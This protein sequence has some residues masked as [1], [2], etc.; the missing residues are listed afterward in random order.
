MQEKGLLTKVFDLANTKLDS[1]LTKAKKNIRHSQDRKAFYAEENSI[2]DQGGWIEKSSIIPFDILRQISERDMVATAII[3]KIVNRVAAFARPQKDRYSLGY[4]FRLRD[5]DQKQVKKKDIKNIKQLQK[6]LLYTGDVTPQR[7]KGDIRNFDEFLR[8]I[9]RDAL[10]YNQI[11]IE[12]IYNKSNK[13]SYFVPVAGGSIRYAV[14][15]LKDKVH[16]FSELIFTPSNVDSREKQIA[17]LNAKLD[18]IKYVQVYKNQILTAFTEEELIYKQRV[19]SVEIVYAGYAPGELEWLINTI[20]SHRIAE[21]HNEIFFK[22]GHAGNGILNIKSEMTDEDLIGI[23]RMFQRQAQGVR[24][25]HRQIIFAVPQGLEWHAMSQMTNRDMEFSAWMDYLIK[26]MC[27]PPNTQVLL[28]KGYTNI[29]NIKPNDK[30]VTHNGVLKTVK[31]TQI[32]DF[33]GDL[34]VVSGYGFPDIKCT[35]EHPFYVAEMDSNCFARDLPLGYEVK[36]VW[37]KANELKIGDRLVV[38]KS[39]IN[40]KENCCLDAA[41]VL[42]NELD[43]QYNEEKIWLKGCKVEIPRWFDL[44]GIFGEILGWYAAKGHH[45][46]NYT[47]FTLSDLDEQRWGIITR[48]SEYFE[49]IG[50]QVSV[51][52]TAENCWRVQINSKIFSML[53]ATICGQNSTDKKVPTFIDWSK[54]AAKQFLIGY[55][56]GDGCIADRCVRTSSISKELS[57]GIKWL[58]WKLGL[59]ASI[60]LIPSVDYDDGRNRKD[61]W[62]VRCGGKDFLAIFPEFGLKEQQVEKNGY[63]SDEN[64][65]YPVIR[66]ITLEPYKGL[67][68]NLEVED[69]NSYVVEGLAVHNCAVY[70]INPSEIN[71]DISRGDSAPSLSDS[72][73]RNEVILK[74]TRNSSLRP[75]L[76]WI[77]TVINDEILPKYDKE[78]AEEYLFEFVGLDMED[79]QKELDRIKA[80]ISTYCTINEIRAEYQLDPEPYGDIILDTVYLQYRLA[81]EEQGLMPPVGP[82]GKPNTPKVGEGGDAESG[83]GPETSDEEAGDITGLLNEVLAEKGNMQKYLDLAKAMKRNGK[84]LDDIRNV[85]KRLVLNEK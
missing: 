25:A 78:L 17:E 68:Y 20:A 63:C 70:G 33:D 26:L 81:K 29:E 53:F 52:K 77:E 82:D 41:M 76:R 13:L 49:S 79:E 14:K 57:Y 1:F 37:K 39:K 48:I 9:V 7:R 69:D 66:N 55:C 12:C 84:S 60:S 75:M 24:N 4:I 50:L 74:D 40:S 85:I 47:S 43:I 28:E 64:Y 45:E 65:Y 30:V 54:E 3:N 46:K 5:D 58:F 80:K 38:P 10:I 35:P 42:K 6:Y 31:N 8:I 32:S 19:P 22:Q 56:R 16:D 2:P 71:F 73:Y 15:D 61:S 18:Q 27:F 59:H 11:A 62:G 67:V 83:T 72:G 21:S 23:R 36:Y 34:V 51:I 44:N